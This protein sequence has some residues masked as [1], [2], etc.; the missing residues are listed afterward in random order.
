MVLIGEHGSAKEVV[1][2]VQE[3]VEQL[4]RLLL[5][6]D[7]A[8]G[9]NDDQRSHDK[10]ECLSYAGKSKLNSPT[11]QLTILIDLYGSCKSVCVY[12]S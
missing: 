11:T 3:A 6:S 2:A 10:E 9:D 7:G 8:V 5:D 4:E 12:A 1:M